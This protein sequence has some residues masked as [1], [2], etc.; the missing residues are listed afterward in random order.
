MKTTRFAERIISFVLLLIFAV[1]TFG[2]SHEITSEDLMK[3]VTP[4]TSEKRPI[5]GEITDTADFAVRLLQ[6]SSE[7]G[8]NTLISPL[9]VLAAL[10]MTVN[11]AEENTLSEM[12]DTIGVEREMLNDI[13]SEY[14]DDLPQGEKYKLNVAN[15]IWFTD[16][17][18]F[19]VNGDFL[20]KNAD[21][22]RADIYKTAFDKS[23]LNDINSW[24][25][26]ETDGMI[27]NILDE[28]PSDAIMYLVNALA[29]DAEWRVT[30]EKNQVKK[31]EFHLSDGSTQKV[32]FMN[33]AESKYLC[34]GDA[35]GF[36]KYYVGGKYAF[37]A[38]LPQEGTAL[39]DYVDSLSGAK[40][41]DILTNAK[42]A[43]VHTSIPKFEVEYGTEMLDALRAMGIK[44]AFDPFN[45]DFSG[46]GSST[47]GNIF[48]S[49]VIHKTYI[50]VGEKGTQAGAATVVEMKDGA[51]P[52]DINNTK[53]VY[54]DRPFLYMIIDCENNMPIFMGTL[55]SVK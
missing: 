14:I 33:G 51:A 6:S 11:G 48:I 32:E 27:K 15:S 19:T 23:T 8:K 12:T 43:T 30:Y 2:C 44:D 41:L 47:G 54:L 46:L 21:T 18:R 40:L 25:E 17:E 52:E 3:N 50:S 53:Y 7:D 28:I 34:D 22:Y 24:V 4:T 36:I 9:S 49:R 10:A 39:S 45:A 31:G 13:L 5:E 55:N 16:D 42:N 35:E 29:F 38:I 1:Y 20:Q 26:R 37:A